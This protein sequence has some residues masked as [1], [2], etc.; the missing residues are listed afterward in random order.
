MKTAV[1]GSTGYGGVEL[2]RLLAA[3]PHFELTKLISTSKTGEALD[4]AF[5]HL[6]HLG[7]AFSGLNVDE[8]AEQVDL[9]FF[10]TPAGVSGK[11]APALAERNVIVVDLSGDFRL[12]EPE[13][14]EAWYGKEAPPRTWMEKTVYGLSEWFGDRLPEAQLIANPGCYPTASLLALL[15][16]LKEKVIDPAMVIIDGK[17]GVS[18]AGRKP[19]LATLFC[20]VNENV[21]PYKADR[22]QHTPEME[23]FAEICAD[24]PVRIRFVPHLVPMN[25][26]ILITLYATNL[27]NY[28]NRDLFDLYCETYQNRPFVRVLKEG[29]PETKAVQGSNFCDI[30]FHVDE[31]TGSI[32]VMAAIDNL[33]KGAAGQAV[34][35]ANLRC[36]WPEESGLTGIPLYP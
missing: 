28:T 3:H 19:G 5:P 33:M 6:R 17:S 26:G 32:V 25:R 20:E 16:L 24:S 2:I 8:L 21:R 4:Q 10:A 9:V 12:G 15:P 30:G 27:N 36:G 18:G 7:Y 34:Q 1:I 11:Y 29:W 13:V 35:N 22:H 23:R 31:R 14:Y